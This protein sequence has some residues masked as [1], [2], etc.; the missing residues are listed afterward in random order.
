MK[1]LPIEK[2][3]EADAYT[4]NH[5]PITDLELMERAST[6]VFKWVV[7]HLEHDSTIRAFC[8][9]GNN[10]GDGLALSRMLLQQGYKV[11][12]YLIRF[13]DKSSPSCEAN[14]LRLKNMPNASITELTDIDD[15]PELH[16]SDIILDAIF[17]SGLSRAVN[18]FPAIVID[19]INNSRAFTLSIDVPS[20]LF[21]DHS[22]LEHPGAIIKAAYTLTFQ[23]PKFSFLF[24]END[25]YL[26]EWEVVPI[27]LHPEYIQNIEV[28]NFFIE[29]EFCNLLMKTRHKY[30]HKGVYGHGLLIAGSKG[31]MGA[32]VLSA[33]AAL[34][35]GAGLITT[36]VPRKSCFVMQTALPESMC[37]M[38]ENDDYF[39]MLPDVSA[40]NAIA[41]GP[42]LGKDKQTANALKLLIQESKIPLI[43]D[44]DA[45]NIISEN[46]TWLPFI[47]P[48]SIFTPHPKEFIR[49]LGPS[50]NNFERH[51]KQKAFSIKYQCYII[52][53]GA[54]TSISCPDG[55][56]YFNSTGNPG[57]ATAG[58]GDVLTGVL[59][60]L[61]ARGYSSLEASILGVYIHGLAGDIAA[62]DSGQE[63]LIASD[64]IANLG[65]AFLMVKAT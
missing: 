21:C 48:F 36:H 24:A 2:I 46:K 44:A 61:K 33:K 1:I 18:G 43:F 40:Y 10:G 52:L 51:E 38:D 22:N 8:G 41:V 26:G 6:Q 42:G 13:S 37:S 15:L 39:S 45:I 35:S 3:R 47:P 5:E 29:S 17:G 58:S 28:D 57:M 9:S 53:K 30:D 27:G 12:T 14:L 20:G 25:Q 56:F 31:K 65:E 23:F 19:H 64:I 59:L 62:E 7:K 60:G 34:R 32:A 11:E 63:S 55:K 16:V 49:L 50:A 4:I 54:H